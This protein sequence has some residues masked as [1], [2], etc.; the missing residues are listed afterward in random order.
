[1]RNFVEYV[2]S[3][4]KFPVDI[5]ELQLLKFANNQEAYDVNIKEHVVR[6]EIYGDSFHMLPCLDCDFLQ[7]NFYVFRKYI[8][9]YL[10]ISY[11]SN[12]YNIF[13]KKT[14]KKAI[15]MVGR[16]QYLLYQAA[17]EVHIN[18][19]ALNRCV[20]PVALY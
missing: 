8:F 3:K 12:Y 19:V 9:N 6:F 18:H 10:F 14:L 16:V 11:I 15:Q 5:V 20:T 4:S 13:L 2:Q 17:S 7:G 1:M